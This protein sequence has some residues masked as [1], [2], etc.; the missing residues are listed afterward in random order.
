MQIAHTNL[1]INERRPYLVREISTSLRY[2]APNAKFR[3][4]SDFQIPPFLLQHSLTLGL[5]MWFQDS[6]TAIKFHNYV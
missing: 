4:L 5:D 1:T 2:S 6:Y 3:S